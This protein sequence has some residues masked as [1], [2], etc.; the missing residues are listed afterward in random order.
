MCYGMA[1]HVVFTFTF[2]SMVRGYRE[3]QSIWEVPA[4][5]EDSIV[6][7]SWEIA[8]THMPWL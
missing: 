1:S 4:V 8:T 5:G 3:Y 6:I 2:E 7:A